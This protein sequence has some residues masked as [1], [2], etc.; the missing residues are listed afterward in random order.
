MLPGPGNSV[1]M[2]VE[3]KLAVKKPWAIL[4]LKIV[5]LANSSSKW[6]GL[7][8]PLTSANFF[9]SSSVTTFSIVD[10]IPT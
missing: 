9:I 1:A 10:C 4:P 6:T 3:I 5:F 8:S 2:I 7:K